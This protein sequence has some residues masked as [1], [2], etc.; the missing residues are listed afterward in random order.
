VT[1]RKYVALAH[2]I[3][4]AETAEHFGLKRGDRIE[5]SER[6]LEIVRYDIAL[7]REWRETER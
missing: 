5:A 4:R 3:I 2:R 6:L 1:E 7:E